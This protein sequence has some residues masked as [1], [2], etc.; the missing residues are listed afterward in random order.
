VAV[1]HR[2]CSPSGTPGPHCRGTPPNRSSRAAAPHPRDFA[3]P[4]AHSHARQQLQHP[5]RHCRRPHKL[6]CQRLGS[7]RHLPL[8]SSP[9]CSHVLAIGKAGKGR[10][11]LPFFSPHGPPWPSSLEL[12]PM[13]AIALLPPSPRTNVR[14]HRFA[15]PRNRCAPSRALPWPGMAGTPS[16]ASPLRHRRQR[17]RTGAPPA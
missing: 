1:R 11:P 5:R 8:T 2:R 9:P 13:L 10:E 14:I 16:A 6:H 7:A 17:A 12:M 3:S 4:P 15:P